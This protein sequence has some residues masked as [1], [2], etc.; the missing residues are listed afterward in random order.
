[1][2]SILGAQ[3]YYS[4]SPAEVKEYMACTT[5]YSSCKPRWKAAVDG[6]GEAFRR[7]MYP[8]VAA[9][10]HGYFVNNCHRHHNIDG[11]E[12][13][14]TKINGNWSLLNSVAN[15]IYGERFGISSKLLDSF[16]PGSN[17]TC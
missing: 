1:M 15:W 16:T 11:D 7:K 14:S 10:Q 5:N 3:A 6:W 12:A 2:E 9:R 4:L 17:P 13:F 8:V